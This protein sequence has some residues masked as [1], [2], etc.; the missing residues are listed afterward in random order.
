MAKLID[1]LM[2]ANTAYKAQA[3][4]VHVHTR[5]AKATKGKK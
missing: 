4:H 2:A 1:D 3:K 5:P